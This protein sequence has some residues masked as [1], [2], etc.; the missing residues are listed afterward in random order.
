MLKPLDSA[1]SFIASISSSELL[2]EQI[3]LTSDALA[4]FI[5]LE[6]SAIA[7]SKSTVSNLLL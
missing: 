1:K 5:S 7:L 2:P 6:A 3:T 4:D